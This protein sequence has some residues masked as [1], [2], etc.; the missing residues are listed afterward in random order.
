MCA[1]RVMPGEAYIGRGH[2]E[3]GARAQGARGAMSVRHGARGGVKCECGV[4]VNEA[5]GAK[6]EMRV[7]EAR[8]RAHRHECARMRRGAQDA[9]CKARVREVRAARR[10]ARTRTCAR[11]SAWLHVRHEHV[12][13]CGAWRAVR[14]DQSCVHVHVH[15]RVQA[16]A[17]CVYA[18]RMHV[19]A[20]VS[21]WACAW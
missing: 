1:W 13:A 11:S 6:R 2:R 10:E 14:Y 7:H 5:R 4:R 17:L 16:C 12:T 19:R 3:R 21:I 9:E 20:H 18:A 8:T 15:T